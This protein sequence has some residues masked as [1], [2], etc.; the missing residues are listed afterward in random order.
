M[1]VEA[2]PDDAQRRCGEECGENVAHDHRKVTARA[3]LP[4]HVRREAVHA[5]QL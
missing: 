2:D 5:G 3:R 1:P 4:R